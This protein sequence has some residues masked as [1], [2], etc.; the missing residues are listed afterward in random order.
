VRSLA[1]QRALFAHQT[2][3]GLAIHRPAVAM[4]APREAWPHPPHLGSSELRQVGAQRR[5]RRAA[6]LVAQWTAV[7]AKVSPDLA[8]REPAYGARL[9][10]DCSPLRGRRYIFPD[11]SFS[12]WRLS[13]WSATIRFNRRFAP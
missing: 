7:Y 3:D 13:A 9:S 10:D 11:A 8:L 5:L 12:N 4:E 6:T 2:L 1:D